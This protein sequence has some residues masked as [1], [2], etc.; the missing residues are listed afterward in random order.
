MVSTL[1]LVVA[2]SSSQT[3]NCLSKKY[4]LEIN[5]IRSSSKNKIESSVQP[6]FNNYALVYCLKNI[7][8]APFCVLTQSWT[9]MCILPV[10]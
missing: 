5:K 1:Y 6:S 3:E 4:F 2:F 8:L 7:I 9:C 10:V